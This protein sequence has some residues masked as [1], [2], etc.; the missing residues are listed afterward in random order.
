MKLVYYGFRGT[1]TCVHRIVKA[2]YLRKPQLPQRWRLGIRGKPRAARHRQHFELV[3]PADRSSL[4]SDA[5]LDFAANECVQIRTAGSV[6]DVDYVKRE[7]AKQRFDRKP[8]A[9]AGGAEI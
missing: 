6:R 2:G 8:S 3:S 5:H 1:D 9:G 4:A 7:R